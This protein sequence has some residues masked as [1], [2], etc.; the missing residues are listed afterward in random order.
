M[1]QLIRSVLFSLVTG[2]ALVASVPVS[3]QV[4][5]VVG[6]SIEDG[7]GASVD[8]NK[9][10]NKYGSIVGATVVNLS[11]GGDMTGDMQPRVYAVNPA[12]G[13]VT[14]VGGPINDQRIYGTDATKMAYTRDGYRNIIYWLALANKQT[15]RAGGVE[16][17][18]WSDT[19]LEGIG[20]RSGS[21]GNTKTFTVSGTAAYVSILI[22]DSTGD[23]GAYEIRIDG[24]TTQSFNAVAPGVKSLNGYDYN[25]RLHR[26]AGL[27]SGSHTI[28]VKHTGGSSLYV[29]WAGGNAQTVFPKV[30]AGN[31]FRSTDAAYLIYRGSRPAPVAWGSSANVVTYNTSAIAPPIAEAIAD[32]LNVVAVDEYSAV[33]TTTHLDPDGVHTSDLGHLAIANTFLAAGGYPAAR[34]FTALGSVMIR[35]DDLLFIVTPSGAYKQIATLP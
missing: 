27:S 4:T 8:P 1:K 29:Q 24:G 23:T 32:G 25:N 6:T 34:L 20:R 12:A 2:A 18:S 28:E 3:A 11:H 5:R 35:D 21:T 30:Y 16:V 26:F 9:W 17:G 14:L 13:D 7:T 15:A 31:L 33:N 19:G 22:A 10:R